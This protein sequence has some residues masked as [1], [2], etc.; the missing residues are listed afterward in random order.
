MHAIAGVI[1][2]R[3]GDLDFR[4]FLEG[5]DNGSA[6][7][8]DCPRWR[9]RHLGH[10]GCAR[11]IGLYGCRGRD[12]FRYD[13]GNQQLCARIPFAPGIGIVQTRRPVAPAAAVQRRAIKGRPG[14]RRGGHSFQR[15]AGQQEQRDHQNG[16]SVPHPRG[17][18]M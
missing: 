10:N 5:T 15:I 14:D 18:P 7:G 4:I 13:G 12:W 3:E 6:Q 1:L 8:L 11:C 9:L 2:S 17:C 16:G